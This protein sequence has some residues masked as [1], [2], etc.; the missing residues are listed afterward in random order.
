[1]DGRI[2]QSLNEKGN[3]M[4]LLGAKEQYSNFL[5]YFQQEIDAKGVE[6]VMKEY[7]FAGNEYAD[8]LFVRLFGGL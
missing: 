7:V 1:V 6:A 8:A 3:F 4:S 5:T 2:V